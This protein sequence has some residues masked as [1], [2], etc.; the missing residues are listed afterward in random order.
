MFIKIFN[1]CQNYYYLL[2][3]LDLAF[4]S[5]LVT[6]LA[7]YHFKISYDLACYILFVIRLFETVKLIGFSLS[8][9]R[10]PPKHIKY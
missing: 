6:M 10:Q 2:I 8:T 9:P 7:G 3:Y 4:F 1:F 5:K